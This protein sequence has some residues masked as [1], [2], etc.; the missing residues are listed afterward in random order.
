MVAGLYPADQQLGASSLIAPE[1]WLASEPVELDA[2]RLEYRPDAPA[3][4]IIGREDAARAMRPLRSPERRYSR[5]THALR[6]I[7]PPTLFENRVSYRLLDLRWNGPTGALAF[8]ETTY[9]DMVDVCEALAHE[10]AATHLRVG[11]RGTEVRVGSPR[12]LPFRR[13]VNDRST[14][15]DGHSCHPSTHSRSAV[16]VSARTRHSCSTSVTLERWPSPAD[17]LTSCQQGCSSR[18]AS[19]RAPMSRTSTCGAP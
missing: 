5:Y 6:D 7:D 14:W 19:S 4:F 11:D 18:Q 12:R 8:G 2:I 1:H 3:P 15:H 10:V 13:L 16:I 9:F 17:C